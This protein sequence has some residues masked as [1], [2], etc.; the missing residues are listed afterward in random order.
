M[1]LDEPVI[2]PF[3]M[4]DYGT[5]CAGTIAALSGLYK[6][7]T[8]GGSW[9]GGVSLVGYDCFLQSL[10]LYPKGMVE[11]LKK[12]FRREG[13]Y[14]NKA[15]GLR[16][17]D[18]VDEVGRRALAA[19]REVSPALFAERNFRR[20]SSRGYGGAE[21]MYVRSAVN[22]EGIRVG[23]SRGTRPNGEDEGGW[24]GWEVDGKMV[25]AL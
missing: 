4:S 6:R 19:M 12:R 16:H 17:S 13:F 8:E 24:E 21:M 18:S 7:A 23:F 11:D 5:G 1:D 22:V 3:P 9:W 2:P 14:G 20:G 10:G 25:D 15:G